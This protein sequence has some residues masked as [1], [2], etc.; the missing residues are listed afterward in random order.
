MT[1]PAPIRFYF[2][3][4]SP[5]SYLASERIDA[6]AERHGRRVQWG[7]VLL[8]AIAKAL[9]TVTLTSQPGQAEYSIHDFARSARFMDIPYTHPA[10]FPVS[11][12]T[13][14]RAY[15]WLHGQ[16]CALARR[17]AHEI[18]RAYFADGRNIADAQVVLEIA[19]KVG[20]GG[21]AVETGMNDPAI[22]ERLRA[23]TDTAL[24]AGIFGVPWIVVDKEP[25]WGA[26]RLPQ[27]ERWLEKGGF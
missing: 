12:V 7:P 18:F 23:E 16:D 5:Y 8:G 24:A 3:F 6:L 4:S 13:A 19:A 15:Y 20:A 27:L 10:N 25:F 9:G 11:T 1:T 26:D 22:K 2:D 21:T 17:F 14:A